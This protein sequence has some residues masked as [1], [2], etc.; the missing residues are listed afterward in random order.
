MDSRYSDIFDTNG[1]VVDGAAESCT[2][3]AAMVNFGTGHSRGLLSTTFTMA[4][5]AQSLPL[6]FASTTQLTSTLNVSGTEGKTTYETVWNDE[7]HEWVP[8]TP[9]AYSGIAPVVI[10][11]TLP[12]AL[13]LPQ[14]THSQGSAGT[15]GVNPYPGC[16][17]IGWLL[18]EGTI[19]QKLNEAWGKTAKSGE[20]NGVFMV[21]D[22][23]N[24]VVHVG[25]ASQGV[26]L[27]ES[28]G[29][30]K[31]VMPNYEKD[32]NAF[33]KSIG[34]KVNYLTDAHAHPLHSDYPSVGDM[35]V[36]E[37][38]GGP[39]AVGVIITNSNQY[40]LYSTVGGIPDQDF[41]KK[42][43]VTDKVNMP[44]IHVH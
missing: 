33:V 4:S 16:I 29:G 41:E 31:A 40:S 37:R 18:N 38:M 11:D 5:F 22:G 34:V 36:L 25:V 30:T 21:Y 24:N 20:E 23:E 43:C 15:S 44:S 17:T 28:P 2:V 27:P 3:A 6:R 10:T 19:S 7:Y 42:R 39:G 14:T 13:A 32:Y 8:Q 12:S 1:C 26:H 9:T 35:K